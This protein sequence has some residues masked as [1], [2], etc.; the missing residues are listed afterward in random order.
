MASFTYS[1][2]ALNGTNK[3]GTLKTDPDGYTDVILGALDFFNT[4]GEYYA[5]EPAR[6]L[7][8]LSGLLMKRV[9]NGTLHGEDGHPRPDPNWTKDQFLYRLMDIYEPNICMHIKEVGLDDSVITH[10]NGGKITA[11]MGRVCPSGQGGPALEKSFANKSEN[12]CF[13]L[14][15]ITDD[16][17]DK[18]GT[19][20]RVIKQIFTWDRVNDG[21]ITVANKYQSPALEDA[22]SVAFGKEH[23]TM[24]RNLALS[25]NQGKGLESDTM[26]LVNDTMNKLGW[27]DDRVSVTASGIILPPSARW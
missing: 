19:V 8:D 3:A 21:G 5:L 25:Y 16:F 24:T 4:R 12:V 9:K 10:P 11:I 1:C 6:H 2:T 20:I 18:A 13:S 17:R 23:L 14:R 7:F 27:T 15:A 22:L 26:K